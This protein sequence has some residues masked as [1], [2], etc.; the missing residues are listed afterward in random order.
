M[1]IRTSNFSIKPLKSENISTRSLTVNMFKTSVK[2]FNH[3]LSK[4]EDNNDHE[5]MIQF[6]K[7]AFIGKRIMQL[8][9]RN[10][11]RTLELQVWLDI[12]FHSGACV[13]LYGVDVKL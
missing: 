13:I 6:N 1:L 10:P 3:F 8:M 5:A 12:D 4:S 11:V 7:L 2:E 9:L